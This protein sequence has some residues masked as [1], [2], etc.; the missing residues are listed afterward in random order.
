MNVKAILRIAVLT[1]AAASGAALPGVS[2]AADPDLVQRGAQ[3]AAV[4]DCIVCHT[5][6]GG[7]PFAGGLPIHTPFGTLYSTN[8]TPDTK[9][10][11]GA[12]TLDAFV[13]AMRRGKSSDGHL[14]YPAFPYVHFTHM[15]DADI[16]SVYAF[17]MSRTPVQATAPANKLIFPLNFRPLLA[18]WNLLY[19]HADTPEP[20][21][22]TQ[23][24]QLDRGRYL[25]DGLGHC[26]ACHTP[27][28][29]FGA[30]KKDRTFDGAVIDG[31]DAPSLKTL[32][33]ASTPWTREQLSTYLRTGVASEHGAAA[34][35]MLPVTRS[36]ANASQAD[37]EAMAAYIMSIQTPPPAAPAARVAS[38]AS[39]Q[40]A[41][42]TLFEASCAACHAAHAPMNVVG[43]R[44][45]LSLSTSVNSDSPRNL[46]RV[47]LDGL[48]A[49]GSKASV[50]MPPFAG[51]LT[52]AQIA[53]LANYL[54]AQYSNRTPWQLQADDV[55]KYRKETPTP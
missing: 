18:V 7:A 37:V 35:P 47:M 23:D 42:A 30:E 51:M 50:S 1:I 52:D 26:A 48:P 41:G 45:L 19:L 3:L 39:L 31:W 10:G 11:I 33:G 36:L 27:L 32:L 29:V 44:P 43:G 28:N 25:V 13:Q 12:W 2:P 5:A 14:L 20:M 6:S 16:A 54:R 9:T 15:T 55:A 38:G 49:Q 21:S 40:Q 53:D 34:G 46:V 22:R 24:P 8:I 17:M 4:G